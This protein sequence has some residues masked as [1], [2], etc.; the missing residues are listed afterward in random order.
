MG[1]LRIFHTADWH[2]GKGLGTQDRTADYEVFLDDFLTLVRERKPDVIL[3]AGDV[4]DTAM[5]ANSAQ[6]L[7]YSFISRLAATDVK[8]T[9]ITAGNHDS[10]RFLE[11]PKPLLESMRC[12]VAGETPESEAV[13]LRDA[14][15]TPL[16]GIAAVPFL[17]EGDVRLGSL[18]YTDADRAALFEQ[19]VLRRYEAVRTILADAADGHRIPMV[20]MGHLFVIGSRMRPDAE[21]TEM[22][23]TAF[24]GSL[25]NVRA[26][27]FGTGWDYVAL[28]HIHNSQTVKADVPMRYSG[29]PLSLSYSHKTYRHHIVEVNFDEK[30]TLDIVEHPVKQPRQFI[31]LAGDYETLRNGIIKAG[32]EFE[33]PFVEATLTSDEVVGD[34]VETLI[35][36][37]R[38]CGAIVT[39]VRNEQ[40]TRRLFASEDVSIDLSQLNPSEVFRQYLLEQ[41][42]TDEAARAQFERFGALFQEA[43]EA[44]AV[45]HRVKEPI[46]AAGLKTEQPK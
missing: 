30:G 44:V 13:M 9:V 39:A 29:A 10:Q 41:A 31:S 46:P 17:R 35:R 5:P 18:D 26:N 19:G 28:G 27:A 34:L 20:A 45:E 1:A 37:G 21:P 24:V 3:L 22:P 32:R 23:E 38:E 7:Y 42:E 43:E 16:L 15:G 14:D 4:F 2:L 12:V 11:A 8:L 33:S 40:A 6:K 36:L 25:R